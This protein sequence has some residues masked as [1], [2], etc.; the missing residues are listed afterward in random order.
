MNGVETHL[1][2]PEVCTQAQLVN[3]PVPR[4][5]V[6]PPPSNTRAHTSAVVVTLG[7]QTLNEHTVEEV[8]QDTPLHRYLCASFVV[9]VT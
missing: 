4:C 7:L 8:L 6:H 9:V 1:C 2:F 5:N 3:G